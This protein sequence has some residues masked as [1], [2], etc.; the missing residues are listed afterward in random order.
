MEQQVSLQ[1]LGA[2]GHGPF[3]LVGPLR[4]SPARVGRCQSGPLPVWAAVPVAAAARVG[5]PC[6]PLSV[7]YPHK[8]TLPREK[9]RYR[10]KKQ[11]QGNY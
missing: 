1:A 11:T 8:E 5:V 4:W 2:I 10:L 6:C 7:R 9:V 3:A